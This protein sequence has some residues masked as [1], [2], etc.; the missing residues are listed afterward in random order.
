M[1]AKKGNPQRK[2]RSLRLSSLPAPAASTE[3]TST[4]WAAAQFRQG[5]CMRTVDYPANPRKRAKDR[6]TRSMVA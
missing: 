5:S 4:F 6:L 1:A 3:R 2:H